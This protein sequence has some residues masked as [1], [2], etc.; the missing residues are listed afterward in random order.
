MNDP[1]SHGH[2][3]MCIFSSEDVA[4]VFLMRFY[5]HN[6]F[7]LEGDYTHMAYLQAYMYILMEMLCKRRHEMGYT[8]KSREVQ[9]RNLGGFY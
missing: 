6:A 3:T 5:R 9:S 4:K 7:H 8:S 1:F 2:R